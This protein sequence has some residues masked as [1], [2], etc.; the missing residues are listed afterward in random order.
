MREER[1]DGC[2]IDGPPRV[3]HQSDTTV[4]FPTLLFRLGDTNPSR[5]RRA[6]RFA[7]VFQVQST[8]VH[9]SVSR[10]C[11]C[12]LCTEVPSQ[13]PRGSTDRICAASANDNNPSKIKQHHRTEMSVASP[14]SAFGLPIWPRWLSQPRQKRTWRFSLASMRER[15]A[16]GLRT[17]TSRPLKRSGSSSA[18][19][20][21]ATTSAKRRPF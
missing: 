6:R 18:K 21:A 8:M 9:V 20:C 13:E 2:H 1:Q 7:A 5:G 4:H 10:G 15:L 12:V 14:A 17:T 11:S 19:S 16:A 3:S